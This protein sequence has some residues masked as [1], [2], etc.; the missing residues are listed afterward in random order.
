MTDEARSQNA[1]SDPSC[2]RF[3]LVANEGYAIAAQAT[4]LYIGAFALL[5]V[6]FVPL[7]RLIGLMCISSDHSTTGILVSW[8]AAVFYGGLF[9]SALILAIRDLDALRF[10]ALKIGNGEI[11]TVPNKELIKPIEGV[12]KARQRAINILG[13][14]LTVTFALGVSVM[15]YEL[16]HPE[17]LKSFLQIF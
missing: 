10:D 16:L 14:I 13:L 7:A 2:E 11:V 12:R 5:L 3:S 1:T 4:S 6:L 9:F 8:V 15:I 17:K